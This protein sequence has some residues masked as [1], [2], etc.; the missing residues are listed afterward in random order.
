MI[1]FAQNDTARS[2]SYKGGCVAPDH[3]FKQERQN[4]R[5]LALHHLL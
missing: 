4:A 3:C 2:V 1:D 5:A